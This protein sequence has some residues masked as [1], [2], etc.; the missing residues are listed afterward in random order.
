MILIKIDKV[1]K[2]NLKDKAIDFDRFNQITKKGRSSWP[3]Q[4]RLE[5]Q[6]KLSNEID[7]TGNNFFDWFGKIWQYIWM[8]QWDLSME[9]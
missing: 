1:I 6:I 7:L 9:G 4:R 5:N 8:I 3:D 2:L